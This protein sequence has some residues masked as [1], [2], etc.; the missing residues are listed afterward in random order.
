MSELTK[1]RKLSRP[2]KQR[3]QN[4]FRQDDDFN[5]GRVMRVILSW[6]AIIFVF[7]LIVNV[8]RTSETTEFELDYTQY[9]K[10]LH[11]GQ[12]LE[13]TIKKS[14]FN[15]FDFHGTLLTPA[16]MVTAQGKRNH[17]EKFHVTLPY[18]DGTVAQEWN[19]KGLRYNITKE[20]TTW[21]NALMSALP[22][23]LILGVWLVIMRRMQGVGTKGIF[24]FG[25]SRAKMIN[26]GAPKVTFEAVAG[27]DEAKIE[28]Q[29]VIEFLKEPQKFQRLGGKIPRGVLL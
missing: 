7:F 13:A 5:W 24:S 29:E 12:I 17:V 26:E 4:Q 3:Q 19:E 25:K 22:W 16:D 10:L 14:E 2:R 27:A 23:V 15:N 1:K 11:E 8:F 28:L 6:V 21:M 20:D 18:L 9:L